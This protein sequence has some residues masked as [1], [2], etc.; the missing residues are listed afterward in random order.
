MY[1]VMA[2]YNSTFGITLSDLSPVSDDI[3][4][5]QNNHFLPSTD[6]KL[7]GG[8]FSA[9]DLSVIQL[10]TPK[11]RQVVPPYLIPLQAAA[12]PGDRPNWV[13][14]RDNPFLLRAV[15]EIQVLATVGGAGAEPIYGLLFAGY[16]L[17]PIPAG[18]LYTLHGTAT[19]AGVVGS[20]VSL[21]ITWDQTIPA[22]R[23]AMVS[24]QVRSTNAVAHRWIFK[25]QVLRPGF[26]SQNAVGD[27]IDPY[28]YRGGFG[29]MGYFTTTTYP[30][31]QV[32]CNAADASHDIIMTFVRVS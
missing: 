15:E 21:S 23:Y 20:W 25:D 27:Y 13:D 14:M 30:T 2:H 11:T 7:F 19:T 18:D 28:W 8:Y 3:I 10:A 16:S 5:V 24:S 26:L 17:D 6:L 31:C 12:L 1:H 9:A 29:V 4:S 32:L 22:G